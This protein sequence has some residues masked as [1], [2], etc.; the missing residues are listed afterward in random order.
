MVASVGAHMPNSSFQTYIWEKTLYAVLFTSPYQQGHSPS[1]TAL[2]VLRQG[3]KQQKL[4]YM[5]F[6]HFEDKPSSVC[7]YSIGRFNHGCCI[8]WGMAVRTTL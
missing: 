8:F 1:Q 4:G 6:K 3:L 2:E 7:F 5:V